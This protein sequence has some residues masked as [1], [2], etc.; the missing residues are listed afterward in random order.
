[1][2]LQTKLFI[3]LMTGLVV[4]Y[5]GSSLFERHSN[6]SVIDDFSRQ[7]KTKELERHWHWVQCVQ[8]AVTTSLEKVMSMGDMDLFAQT[9]HEQASLPG[10]LE[11]SLAD[12]AGH[13]A[14][15]T[16][17]ERLHQELPAELKPQLLKPRPEP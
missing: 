1:M 15:S 17:L 11:A 4:V 12:H 6:L 8:Q 7:C 10:L 14:Y 2:K 16:V 3:A 9:I 13:I 5:L